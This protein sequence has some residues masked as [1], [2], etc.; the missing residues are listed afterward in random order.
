[1]AEKT[2]S[3]EPGAS[4]GNP[5]RGRTEPEVSLNPMNKFNTGTSKN[6]TRKSPHPFDPHEV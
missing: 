4:A 5:G 1:M 2:I 3:A 6:R